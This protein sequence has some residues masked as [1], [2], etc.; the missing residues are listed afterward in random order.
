[1]AQAATRNGYCILDPVPSTS[2]D[3]RFQSRI[4][5][6]KKAKSNYEAEKYAPGTKRSYEALHNDSSA[7]DS[8][9]ATGNEGFIL[10]HNFT[11]QN[12]MLLPTLAMACER[13]QMSDRAGAAIASAV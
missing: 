5:Q 1:M 2:T 13:F 10:E 9:E 4:I 8:G 3:I 11:P 6:V 7:Y 12:K